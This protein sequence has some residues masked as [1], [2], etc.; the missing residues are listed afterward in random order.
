[1]DLASG[2]GS[3][4]LVRV[5]GC[6][7]AGLDAIVLSGIGSCLGDGA[8]GSR[9]GSVTSRV[10]SLLNTERQREGTT[11]L[12]Q[13]VMLPYDRPHTIAPIRPPPYDRP[14]TNALIQTLARSLG[15]RDHLIDHNV[16]HTSQ[17]WISM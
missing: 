2:M 3:R 6:D 5:E 13:M 12:A 17:I 1:M 16:T 11:A 7:R 10:F 8:L 9:C 4:D 14:H 15:S